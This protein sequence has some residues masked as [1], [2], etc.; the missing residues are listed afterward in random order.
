[1]GLLLTRLKAW[2]FIFGFLSVCDLLS[3]AKAVGSGA[4]FSRSL[5]E[6]RGRGGGGK[7]TVQEGGLT[8]SG[9]TTERLLMDFK[10]IAVGGEGLTSTKQPPSAASK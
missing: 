4:P 8:A 7:S 5:M 2:S 9:E 3:S 1:M 6:D 10:G